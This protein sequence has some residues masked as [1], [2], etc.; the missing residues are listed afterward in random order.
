[1][2]RRLCEKA[3]SRKSKSKKDVASVPPAQSSMPRAQPN[4]DD[5]HPALDEGIIYDVE[6]D[7]DDDIDKADTESLASEDRPA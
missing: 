5:L 7:D 2:N 1:M 3:P 6:D 4:D